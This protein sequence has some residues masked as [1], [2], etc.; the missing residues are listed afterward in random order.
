MRQWREGKE[1]K[2]NKSN[3]QKVETIQNW[4]N[5]DWKK[6]QKV[7]NVFIWIM[8][9]S[10]IWQHHGARKNRKKKRSRKMVKNEECRIKDK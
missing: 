4:N 7:N 3:I 10:W 5:Y 6:R 2:K 1:E 8:Y 9:H